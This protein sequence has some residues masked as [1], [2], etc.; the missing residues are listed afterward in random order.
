MSESPNK[1]IKFWQELKRRKVFSVVTTY[2]ATAYIII[3]VTNNLVEPLSLP[4]WI[5]KLVILLLGAGLP[6]VVILSWIFDFTP[7]GLKKTES[8]EE[9]G[10]KEIVVKPVKRKLRAS[11][12]L[13]AIL[14]IAVIVLAYPKIFKQNTLERLRSSGERISVAVM[15]FQN[16]TNDTI[17]NI[18]QGGVQ[19]LL[20]TSLSNFEE[21]KIRQAESITELLEN[22]GFTNYASITPSVASSISQKLDVSVIIMG[23]ILKEESKIRINASLIDAKTE[24][25]FKSFILNGIAENIISLTD[26]LSAMVQDYLIMSNLL[27][28]DTPEDQ[29]YMPVSI[30]PQAYKI[31]LEGENAAW[32]GY[33]AASEDMFQQAIAIDSN[34]AFPFIAITWSYY[35]QGSYEEAKKWCIKACEKKNL[36]SKPHKIETDVLYAL[37]F[38]TLNEV[39][40]HLKQELELDDQQPVTQGDLGDTYYKLFQYDKA[41]P[42]LEKAL[43]IYKKWNVKPPSIAFYTILGTSYH[44]T[45]QYRKENKLYKK[46]EKDFPDAPY[47][48]Y[49]QAILS[50]TKGDIVAANEF[51]KIYISLLKERSLPE[52]VIT[53]KLA[54]IY[55]EANI[56]D[57]TEKYYREALSLE[58]ENPIRLNNLAYFLIDK[59]RNIT[60]GMGLVDTILKSSSG[61]YNFMH[62]KGWGLYKQGN[63]QDALKYLQKSD[64]LKPLYVHLLYL[65]LEEV[66]KAVA[67]QKNN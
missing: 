11:Y 36:M 33:Y 53:T 27:K 59:G 55:S 46:A 52:A 25:V 67:N 60:E 56:L 34:F 51:I 31:Y 41:I 22:K 20:I 38:E 3:E 47:L 29:K 4:A 58:P 15:P 5:A 45:G 65:H 64:S 23:S 54:E 8:L 6:V 32:D 42:Y 30:S 61:D 44:K 19:N 49:R 13:N 17:W 12:V 9:L 18:W 26:S 40:G 2:A 66:K 24:A 28:E 1:L 63:Y 35:N 57:K 37:C 62:T 39:V 21:L 14:I 7:Q 48:L 16:M 43:E 10:D 50:L